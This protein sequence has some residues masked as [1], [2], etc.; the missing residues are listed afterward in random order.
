MH[1]SIITRIAL[2]VIFWVSVG[3]FYFITFNNNSEIRAV[4]YILSVGLLPV[5]FFE[6]YFFNYILI[7]KFLEKKRYGRFFF[8]SFYTVLTSTW[9]S[10]LIVMF[11]LIF[12]LERDASLDPAVLHPELQVVSLN[13]IVFLAISIK[14]VKRAFYMQIEKSEIEKN[15]LTSELKLKEAELKLLKAQVHPHFLFNTLN[16]L[17]GLTL[18]KSDDAPK[19]VLQLSEI[20]DY[21][22]YRCDDKKVPLSDE[23]N[24]LKN[25]IEIEK[26][27]YSKK[28]ELKTEFPQNNNSLKIAPLILLPFVENAFKHGVSNFP[29]VGFVKI[30]INIVSKN[31][32]FNIK[33]SR[34]H[35][36]KKEIDSKKGIGLVNVKK[37][38]DLLYPEKYILSIDEQAETFSVNLTLELE[39]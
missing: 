31:L 2:H 15:I 5:A 18:E 14:Q 32:I 24:N 20:L 39:V 30:D 6:A 26:I 7:P 17:Y 28:L 16:N 1:K 12:I 9:L 35:L 3:S 13:F 36:I 33:N 19:L 29:G 37:R 23:L 27:R 21:I 25:Y 4:S 11:T 38:L 8:F 10:F 34:N 22:L